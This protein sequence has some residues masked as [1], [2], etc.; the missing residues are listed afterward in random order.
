MRVATDQT[1]KTS[2]YSSSSRLTS[3]L[4]GPSVFEGDSFRGPESDFNQ[5]TEK[6]VPRGSDP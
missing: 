6:Y 4:K 1:G 5:L 3:Y 2:T